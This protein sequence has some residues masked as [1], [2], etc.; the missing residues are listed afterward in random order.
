M[1]VQRIEKSKLF[2]SIKLFLRKRY[3]R[4]FRGRMLKIRRLL[5]Y[6][7]GFLV[8]IDKLERRKHEKSTTQP[9]P[10][11]PLRESVAGTKNI[12]AFLLQGQLCFRDLESAL[13]RH[14]HKLDDFSNILD[15]GCG[16]A[17]T[18]RWF[19]DSTTM[20]GRRLCGVDVD[21]R[22]VNWCKRNLNIAMVDTCNTEPPLRF[23][24]QDFNLIYA[25]SVFSH[26]EETLHL[27]WLEE[28]K[29]LLVPQGLA[30][31]SIH[32]NYCYEPYVRGIHQIP[33]ADNVPIPPLDYGDN[34][35]NRLGFV[36]DPVD[37]SMGF[38]DAFISP[39]YVQERWTQYFELLEIVP[40][41]VTRLQDLVVLRN[42]P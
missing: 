34:R 32:G 26:L 35:L 5:Y 23:R 3:P 36:F 18:L 8:L 29:R 22:A 7:S 41:G 25:I 38:G 30:L 17:R 9:V 27:R 6:V 40:L 12:E 2:R 13:A 20:S 24:S 42:K 14:D 15:F 16:C 37:E 1:S 28:L 21:K 4:I 19:D 33:L 10:P 11:R 31:L 39:R